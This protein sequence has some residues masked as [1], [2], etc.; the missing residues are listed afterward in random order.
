MVDRDLKGEKI[1]EVE[2]MEEEQIHRGEKNLRNSLAQ[3]LILQREKV[4]P[5]VWPALP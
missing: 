1:E 5:R 3:P 2:R 4:R